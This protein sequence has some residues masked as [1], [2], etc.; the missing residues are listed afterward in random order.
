[1]STIARLEKQAAKLQEEIRG[2]QQELKTASTP[3]KQRRALDKLDVR[4]E[5][6]AH[7]NAEIVRSGLDAFWQAVTR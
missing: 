3:T 1:M 4:K 5:K 6:L 2:L 7:I